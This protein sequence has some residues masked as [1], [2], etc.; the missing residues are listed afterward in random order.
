MSRLV[1]ALP[2]LVDTALSGDRESLVDLMLMAADVG[3][4]TRSRDP[5]S[6]EAVSTAAHDLAAAVA[7][8][9]VT[10][11]APSDRL[12]EAAF[13]VADQVDAIAVEL[14]RRRRDDGVDDYSTVAL[15][16]VE[17]A[18]SIRYEARAHVAALRAGVRAHRTMQQPDVDAAAHL[19][20]AVGQL[21]R[22]LRRSTADRLTAVQSFQAGRWPPDEDD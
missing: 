3:W 20:D 22:T 5:Q 10:G 7:D 15:V 6:L 1:E 4:Q 14:S 18:T 21:I 12:S 11:V 2:D 19:A 13:G 9:Y 17:A 8:C 16:G